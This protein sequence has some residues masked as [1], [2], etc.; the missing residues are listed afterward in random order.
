MKTL[1]L[2]LTALLLTNTL[3]A[4]N[5]K[6]NV[7]SLFFSDEKTKQR[8]V[9]KMNISPLVVKSLAFMGEVAL[10]KQMSLGLGY[11]AVLERYLPQVFFAANVKFSAPTFKGST[12][13]PEFRWYPFHK[14]KRQAPAGFYLAGYVRHASYSFAQK[15]TYHESNT[16]IDFSA[17]AKHTYKGTTVGAMLGLQVISKG[18]FTFDWW[19]VGGGIGSGSY[20]Y[21]W[22]N[23]AANFSQSQQNEA[24]QQYLNYFDKFSFVGGK[25]LD[26]TTSASGISAT[27]KGLPMYSTRLMGFCFGYAF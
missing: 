2:F 7:L 1:R 10:N 4:L 3:R 17:D 23:P 25:L 26:V 22:S 14:K 8:I 6:P 18:G 20:T 5:T 11:T 9:L 13:T 15:M 16:G 21:A 19:I 24:L 27:A 12:I